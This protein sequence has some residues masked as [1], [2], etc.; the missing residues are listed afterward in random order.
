MME[1]ANLAQPSDGL[2]AA[3]AASRLTHHGPN[4]VA[5]ER[6]ASPLGL[7]FRQF[8]NPIV[9]LLL[10]AAVIAAALGEWLTRSPSARS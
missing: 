6:T 10:A 4:V 1:T 3:E 7:L 5:R 8:K 9:S 2:T